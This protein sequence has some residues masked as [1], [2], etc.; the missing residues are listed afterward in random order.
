MW[1]ENP[2]LLAPEIGANCS[3]APLFQKK[4]QL[5]LQKIFMA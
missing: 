4:D 2:R 1:Q 5:K 3:F